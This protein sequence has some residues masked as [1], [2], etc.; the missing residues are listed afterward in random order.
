[1]SLSQPADA[2]LVSM[3][4]M[5][6]DIPSIQ[7]AT[8]KSAL[9]R[10][11]LNAETFELFVDYAAAIG[12]TLY[13]GLSSRTDYVNEYVFCRDYFKAETGDDMHGLLGMMPRIGLGSPEREQAVL[14]AL[15]PVT[16]EFLDR[17]VDETDWSAFPV[18][19]FSLTYS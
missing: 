13:R 14:Q 17:C 7:L 16:A 2:A 11:G 9:R 19:G 1:M 12:P 5:G 6:I 15:E 8:L 4:W 10:E 3:P 18:I